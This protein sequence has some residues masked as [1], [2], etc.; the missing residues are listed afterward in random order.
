MPRVAP[1]EKRRDNQGQND[2][3]RHLER[4]LV[5]NSLQAATGVAGNADAMDRAKSVPLKS[6]YSRDG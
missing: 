3:K 4:I 6:P 5:N 1:R 2:E